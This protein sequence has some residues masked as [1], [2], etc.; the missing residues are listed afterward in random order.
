MKIIQVN[1]RQISEVVGADFDYLDNGDFK[2]FNGNSE[3][4]TAG[5]IDNPDGGKDGEPLTSDDYA[6]LLAPR[7]WY[8]RRPV[9][10]TGRIQE[11]VDNGNNDIPDLSGDEDGSLGIS[12][13]VKSKI[14]NLLNVIKS[15]NSNNKKNAIILKYLLS[16]MPVSGIPNSWKVE[17]R[18]IMMRV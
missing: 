13:T 15:S 11:D 7:Y 12:S 17:L 3:V 14:D 8:G 9:Y 1:K 18:N 16:N 2:Q 4:S 5:K 10:G 6:H